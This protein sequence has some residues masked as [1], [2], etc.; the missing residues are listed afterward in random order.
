MT[1]IVLVDDHEMLLR[2]LTLIF[3]T[4]DNCD[5]VASTTDGRELD[6]I[7]SKYQPD[8]I[9]TDAKMPV[10]DGLAVVSTYAPKLPVLVLTTFDDAA[11]V[12][13][14]IDAG[15]AGYLLKDVPA[16]SLTYAINT[17]AAGGMVFDPRITRIMKSSKLAAL[18]RSETSVA[19]LVARGMSN[20]AIAQEL[21]LA[22]GT[23]KNHVSTLLRKLNAADRT[24][25]ALTLAKAFGEL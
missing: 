11:L 14:L 12:K 23:I 22:E 15:A 3:E 18:T 25:L 4:I 8:V 2:G 9:V 19:K 6:S 1:K 20:R 17:V 5:V 21:Y 13:S 16:E 10:F 7:I 24:A